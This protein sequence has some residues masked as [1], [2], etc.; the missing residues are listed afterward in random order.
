MKKLPPY[1]ENILSFLGEKEQKYLGTNAVSAT[2]RMR[3]ELIN[4]SLTAK[5]PQ[6]KDPNKKITPSVEIKNEASTLPWQEIVWFY[7]DGHSV[8]SIAAHY[9]AN[10]EAVIRV[11]MDKKIRPRIKGKIGLMKYQEDNPQDSDPQTQASSKKE[12]IRKV[13]EILRMKEH[14]TQEDID[15]LNEIRSDNEQKTNPWPQ[16]NQIPADFKPN[17]KKWFSAPG[18]EYCLATKA[19]IEMDGEPKKTIERTICVFGGKMG[20]IYPFSHGDKWIDLSVEESV[21]KYPNAEKRIVEDP[22]GD[23]SIIIKNWRSIMRELIEKGLRQEGY[24]ATNPRRSEGMSP[25]N[26]DQEQLKV[27]REHETEHTDSPDE[28][29]KIAMDH[30]AEDPDYYKKLEKMEAGACDIAA[31]SN[32]RPRI[33]KELSEFGKAF[34]DSN[35][36]E[37]VR[38]LSGEAREKKIKEMEH[39][40]RE[41]E[42]V[43]DKFSDLML[44]VLFGLKVSRTKNDKDPT[45][46]EIR[47]GMSEA[48]TREHIMNRYFKLDIQM[49]IITLLVKVADFDKDGLKSVTQALEGKKPVSDLANRGNRLANATVMFNLIGSTMLDKVDPNHLMIALKNADNKKKIASIY[50]ATM[51]KTKKLAKAEG[52]AGAAKAKKEIA[53]AK[54]EIEFTPDLMQ[55]L[56][57]GIPLTE[58]EEATRKELF[59]GLG[60]SR[61]AGEASKALS[62]GMET[63]K[64]VAKG[65]RD[66]GAPLG[67]KTFDPEQL[68]RIV[69]AD[70]IAAELFQK[71]SQP[72]ILEY[73]LKQKKKKPKK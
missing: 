49:W 36:G 43:A 11:L 16:D 38:N 26:F 48:E 51:A 53:E 62:E 10:P 32:P 73:L 61:V 20:F 19:D 63:M 50:R 2:D 44:S 59:A 29:M 46:L 9:G 33:Q 17:F 42:I 14:L 71:L 54:L 34:M 5:N 47:P 58:K 31:K 39:L 65:V 30:L 52:K 37:K 24:A 70:P 28:A 1:V 27:G 64:I 12:I 67:L 60:A 57:S 45:A 35:L 40:Y 18:N 72:E 7:K 25:S 41:I 55:K 22:Y 15:M 66:P 21:I 56:G 8:D 68:M 69:K 6:P 4:E 23:K 3:K 13:D